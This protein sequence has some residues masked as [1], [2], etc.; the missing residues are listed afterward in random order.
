MELTLKYHACRTDEALTLTTGEGWSSASIMF[1]REYF[2]VD[3]GNPDSFMFDLNE[4]DVC[5]LQKM[6]AEALRYMRDE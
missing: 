3:T 6:L 1:D 5:A 4:Q 2:F